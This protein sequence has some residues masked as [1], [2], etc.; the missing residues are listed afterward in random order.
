MRLL[1]NIYRIIDSAVEPVIIFASLFSLSALVVLGVVQ[2]FVFGYQDAWTGS[3]PIYFFL[4]VTWIG[5][6]YNLKT[7][8]QLRFSEIRQA[9]QPFGKLLCLMLD[10]VIWV[11]VAVVVIF[12]SVNQVMIA[13]DNFAIVQGT[14]SLQQ[15]WFY[16]A[17]PLGWALIILRAIQ[18]SI[19]DVRDYLENRP[20]D[21]A[22]AIF[23]AD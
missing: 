5:A 19:A 23:V 20:L 2:R 10:N 6:A 16:L 17:T 8:Q 4:W 18:N 11:A 3:L 22:Q 7:R 13:R 9:L 21:A 12:H 15:W 14:Q 1:R